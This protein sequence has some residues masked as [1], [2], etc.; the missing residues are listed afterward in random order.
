VY[1]CLSKILEITVEGGGIVGSGT[2][3]VIDATWSL[4]AVQQPA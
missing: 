1:N 2:A 3:L 4:E